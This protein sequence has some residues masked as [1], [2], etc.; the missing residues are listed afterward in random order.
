MKTDKRYW[1]CAPFMTC[2][3]QTPSSTPSINTRFSGYIHAQSIGTNRIRSWSDVM[4][5]RTFSTHAPSTVRTVIQTTPWCAVRS[6]CNQRNSTAQ[7]QRG[8]LV[9]MSAR[10]LNQTSWS[11]SLGSS[12]RNLAPCNP[13][14]VPQS[15]GKLCMTLCTALFWLPLG[16][17]PQ[18]HMTGQKSNQPQ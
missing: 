17:G 7:R 16:R 1:S 14:T 5:S 2:A 13:V 11:S 8:K 9:S 3:V 18:N 4:L 12:R 15:S 6:G 10:C